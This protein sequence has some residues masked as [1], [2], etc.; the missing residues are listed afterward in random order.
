M[1]AIP[2]HASISKWALRVRDAANSDAGEGDAC[3]DFILS[4]TMAG[5]QGHRR[6]TG[7]IGTHWASSGLCGH[8]EPSSSGFLVM[9]LKTHD[10]P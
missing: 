3:I 5:K 6:E 8:G 2:S 9:R 7:A 10:L 1:R 4:V